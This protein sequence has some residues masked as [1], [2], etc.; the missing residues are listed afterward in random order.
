M[1]FCCISLYLHENFISIIANYILFIYI[2]YLIANKLNQRSKLV[3]VLQPYLVS[4]TSQPVSFQAELDLQKVSFFY[5]PSCS[6]IKLAI[7]VVT[8]AIANEPPFHFHCVPHFY[9]M[10]IIIAFLLLFISALIC[11]SYFFP[12]FIFSR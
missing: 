6:T 9:K 12:P 4:F 5:N 7:R 1:H 3:K 11:F 8:L 2:L 10:F